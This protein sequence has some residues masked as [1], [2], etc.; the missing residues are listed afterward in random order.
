MN[1]ELAGLAGKRRALF[2]RARVVKSI[3]EYFEGEGFLEVQTPVRLPV[4]APETHIDAV[5]S[6]GWFLQTSP[7]L[8]MKRLLAAGF[9]KI[10]QLGPCFREGERGEKHLPEFT[11]L[12]W[13]R[14]GA[15]YAALMGDCRGLLR[16]VADDLGAEGKLCREGREIDLHGEWEELTVREAFARFAGITPEEAIRAGT[17]DEITVTKIEPNLGSGRPSILKD[18]PASL[19][20]LSRIKASDPAVCERFELYIA[21]LELANGFSE[22][23]DPMEQRERFNRERRARLEAG[24]PVRPMP[25]PFLRDLEHLPPSAGIALGVDRLVMLFAGAE[26]IDDVV[27]FSP[28]EL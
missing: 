2:L 1:K 15:D 12:E 11:M 22:L 3:R 24:K 14:S 9:E 19:S 28:E 25:E 16:R 17:F 20:A 23:T 6:D 8:C 5:S 10:F 21:G 18:Y 4:V 13:Y 26:S 27:A 7:E